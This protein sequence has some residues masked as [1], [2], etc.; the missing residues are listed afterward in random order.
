MILRGG[1]SVKL[2]LTTFAGRGGE[3]PG[4]FRARIPK[5]TRVTEVRRTPRSESRKVTV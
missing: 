5:R 4:D 2:R 3:T 1:I